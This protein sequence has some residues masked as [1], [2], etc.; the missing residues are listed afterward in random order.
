VQF[1]LKK[2]YHLVQE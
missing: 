1:G 2:W